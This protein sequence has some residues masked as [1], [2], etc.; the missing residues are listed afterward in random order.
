[1]KTKVLGQFLQEPFFNQL[2][3]Q[4]QLGYVVMSRPCDTRDVMG[5][6][7]LVQ[8]PKRSCAH[9]VKCVNDYLEEMRIRVDQMTEEEFQVQVGAVLSRLQEKDISHSQRHARHWNEIATHYYDFERQQNDIEAIQRLTLEDLKAHFT[10]TFFSS[11]SKR[12]DVTL[13]STTHAEEHSE[14]FDSNSEHASVSH[15][16]AKKFESIA[17]LKEWCGEHPDTYKQNYAKFVN[18]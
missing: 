6:Q 17:A 3:T 11:E 15:L 13:T 4:Q 2:R 1:L 9:L 18:K 14:L 12:L 5:I 7:F 8:S 16:K 10:A